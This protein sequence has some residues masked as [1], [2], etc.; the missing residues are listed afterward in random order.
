[1]ALALRFIHRDFKDQLQDSDINHQYLTNPATG[2][3]YDLFGVLYEVP[4]RN[5]GTPKEVQLPDGKPD[6]FIENPFFNQVLRVANSNTARYNAIELELR[7]RLSRRWEMQGSYVYSRAL[8]N[9]EDYLSKVG[10]D[11][12]VTESEFGYLSYDQRHVVKINAMAY[13]PHDWQL[14]TTMTWASGLPY[15]VITRFFAFDNLDY[16]Q[17]RTRFGYTDFTNNFGQFIPVRR[18]SLRNDATLDVNVHAR[19]SLVIGRTSAALFLDVSNL[20]NRDDLRIYSYEPTP[21]NAIVNAQNPTANGPL[22]LNAER[23]FGRRFQ[24]GMQFE[25]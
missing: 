1:V 8:G 23:R 20:L 5:G 21:G 9:A 19:K 7:R 24:I 2:E 4:G 14:G 11:P 22:S 16:Q 15:S 6:L 3:P 13:L 10:N 12:S 25:F 17:F 18:N